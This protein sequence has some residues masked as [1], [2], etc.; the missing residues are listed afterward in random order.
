MTHNQGVAGSSPA[1]PTKQ[2]AAACGFFVLYVGG[3]EACPESEATREAQL[4]PQLIERELY[5]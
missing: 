2:K 5:H 3:R 4:G 1:G